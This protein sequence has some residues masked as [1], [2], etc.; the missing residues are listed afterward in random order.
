MNDQ[1]IMIT[2]L[3]TLRDGVCTHSRDMVY[4]LNKAGVSVHVFTPTIKGFLYQGLHS[5]GTTEAVNA[6]SK[7]TIEELPSTSPIY[8]Q[9]A[10]GSY[11]FGNLRLHRFAKKHANKRKLI[12]GFHEAKRDLQ[13][14]GKLGNFIYSKALQRADKIVTFAHASSNA[15]AALTHKKI[16]TYPLGVP[17]I[18][19]TQDLLPEIPTFVLFGYYLKDKGFEIGLEAFNRLCE[20][21]DKELR[22]VII[23]SLRQR[24]GSSR[25]KS[26]SDKRQYSEFIAK[27][28]ASHFRNRIALHGF[29]SA[30]K[31]REILQKSHYIL[32]PYLNSTQSIL[33][34]SA[35]QFGT[36]VISS[37]LPT[38]MESFGNSGIYVDSFDP[39]DWSRALLKLVQND[40]FFEERKKRAELLREMALNQSMEQIALNIIKIA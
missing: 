23:C 30:D 29:V 25:I 11:W 6:P 22:L 13:I 37:N 32:M 2:P 27:V 38:L 8:I 36:P 12:F 7:V 34:V 20:S 18:Y 10:L 24:V 5:D 40:A 14:L 31:L 33:A 17:K 28:E 21:T 19:P 3:I 4:G 39:E 9:Y 35:K 15:L 1:I 26:R 16:E